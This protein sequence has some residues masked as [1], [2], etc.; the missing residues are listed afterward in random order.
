MLLWPA[1]GCVTL[2]NSRQ[3]AYFL[4][5]V[6]QALLAEEGVNELLYSRAFYRGK[7]GENNL[8]SFT[9]QFTGGRNDVSLVLGNCGQIIG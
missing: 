1:T 9:S 4:G 6:F 3:F 5:V 7:R 2:Q 8:R